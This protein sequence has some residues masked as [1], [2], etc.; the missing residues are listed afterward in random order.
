MIL[1]ET[2]TVSPGTQWEIMSPQSLTIDSH[3]K[4]GESELKMLEAAYVTR[5]L[6]WRQTPKRCITDSR[7]NWKYTV[8]F[9]K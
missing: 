2:V 8:K 5:Q 9:R 1:L 4:K 6:I 3:I 7:M